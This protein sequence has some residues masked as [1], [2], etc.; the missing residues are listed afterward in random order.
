MVLLLPYMAIVQTFS[1]HS[2]T[3]SKKEPNKAKMPRPLAYDQG[4]HCCHSSNS[5]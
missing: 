3:D 4:L 1:M 5:I 2:M